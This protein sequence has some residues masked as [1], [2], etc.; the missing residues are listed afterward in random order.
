MID[1]KREW[2]SFQELFE[3]MAEPNDRGIDLVNPETE[4]YGN[5]TVMRFEVC[6][7]PEK[8]D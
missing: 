6:D 2:I 4:Q 3:D 7:K 8:A 5:T 1:N